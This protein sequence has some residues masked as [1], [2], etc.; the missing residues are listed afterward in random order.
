MLQTCRTCL[1]HVRAP[2]QLDPTPAAAAGAYWSCTPA[3]CALHVDCDH[4]RMKHVHDCHL[5]CTSTK[6]NL[7]AD[8]SCQ[9]G[10]ACSSAT[11]PHVQDSRCSRV[12]AEQRGWVPTCKLP[13]MPCSICLLQAV[14]PQVTQ[15]LGCQ[16]GPATR[17][18]A[19]ADK[20]GGVIQA[21]CAACWSGLQLRMYPPRLT[22]QGGAP[23]HCTRPC[24]LPVAGWA[25]RRCFATRRQHVTRAQTGVHEQ[26]STSGAH[27]KA[28]PACGMHAVLTGTHASN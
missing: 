6:W 28:A 26:L 7:Q 4:N 10:D 19:P 2:L 27:L 16:M 9:A 14:N 18:P 20:E 21:C 15:R 5:P 23:M 22:L 3:A 24:K 25:T 13:C 12:C 1:E 8:T 11:S 17:A